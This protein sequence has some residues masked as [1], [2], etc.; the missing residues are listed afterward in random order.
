MV[1]LNAA[2]Q[3][4]N[5]A[6]DPANSVWLSANA[7]SGK[8]RVLT[9]RVARL[10]LD[11][12]DPQHILCLTY[13]RAAAGEM[14]NR[15]FKRLGRWA[16]M[17]ADDLRGSL[18]SLGVERPLSQDDL[19]AARTLFA[20]AIETP[21]GIKIQT[22]HSFCAAL[23]RR[24]PLEAGISPNVVEIDERTSLALRD[25]VV[26]DMLRGP[27]S[28]TVRSMARQLTDAD[29]SK[30]TA[31]V[32]RA[33]RVFQAPFPE[34]EVRARLGLTSEAPL[35][36]PL[37][38]ICRLA[39]PGLIET[40]ASVLAE[41][42]TNDQKA[43]P[44]LKPLIGRPIDATALPVLEA[45]LLKKTKPEELAQFPTKA[46]RE[47]LG[48]YEA[49]LDA[50]AEEVLALRPTRIA[51]KLFDQT[52][53]FWNFAS[54]FLRNYQQAKAE[55]GWL[56]YDD[57]IER[58]Q[59]L[60]NSPTVADWVLYRLDGGLDHILVDEAQDTSPAQWEII[61][62]IAREFS[63]G[64]GGRED[65]RRT[66]FVVGDKKQSI[67]SFQGADPEAFDRFRADFDDR[68]GAIGQPLQMHSLS[69]SFR[70]APAILDV[71]DAVIGKVPQGGLDRE[72][73]HRAFHQDLP[74][75][76]D[77]W[78]FRTGDEKPDAADW[79]A[80][81]DQ[82][83]PVDPKR[84]LADALAAE[85]SRLI[86]QETIQLQQD[87]EPV[88]RR[89]Q[90]GDFL[91]LFPTRSPLFHE[92]I[93]A[94]KRE[95][96]AVA[97]ADRLRISEELAV[98]DLKALLQ[99]L[100]L[101]EDDLSLAC[102]L[103]SPLFG[104][105]E[106]DL[107]DLAHKRLK[108]GKLWPALRT[109]REDVP[110]TM[111]IIDDLARQAEFLRPYDLLERI[112][113]R[114]D[115]RRRLLGRLGPDAEDA[116]DALLS[117]ALEF[118]SQGAADLT[119]FLVWLEGDA[120]EIKRAVDS[121]SNRIRI[122]TVHGAKGLEA[123]IV[124]LPDTNRTAPSLRDLT[125]TDTETALWRPNSAEEPAAARAMR[126]EKLAAEARERE[127]LLYVAMTRAECWLIVAGAGAKD[128]DPNGW[129]GVIAA[130]LQD[131]AQ[132]PLTTPMGEGLRV[133][134]TPWPDQAEAKAEVGEAKELP[135]AD[136]KIGPL[137]AVEP[138]K[139]FLS[140][141][142]LGGAKALPGESADDDDQGLLYGRLLHLLLE[143]LPTADAS[144]RPDLG[145][146]LLMQADEPPSADMG[147]RLLADAMRLLSDANLA[148]IFAPLTLREVGVT[149]APGGKALFGS[150]D[151]L[152]VGDSRLRIVDFKSNRVVPQS[153]NDVPEGILR[154]LGA[155][156]AMLE[157]IYPEHEIVPEI[158]WTA[159]GER[160]S[161]PHDIVR[162]A[163]ARA[164][165]P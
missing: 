130:A 57:L 56:D 47:A 155:Y 5:D 8:T 76:V 134:P 41:G 73:A 52:R 92:L 15:L 85:I 39:P 16:M 50:L 36:K 107:F 128:P 143:H 148:D 116:I 58:A 25:D 38:A 99:F 110:E 66:L 77:L 115:G 120:T 27:D 106:R 125:L 4:Q 88:I 59:A 18:R 35:E 48:P 142:D 12:V 29:F 165:T 22:I 144:E 13:T 70:S 21:G 124:I 54:A 71:V 65:V 87:G 1:K 151:A 159:T 43:L 7:G 100:A 91:I 122:M 3:A 153:E 53:V 32:M 131:R 89:I 78:P 64:Q 113:I 86:H 84:Q 68:L 111:S 152:I 154:Q 103:R 157:E 126:Q 114:H 62:S 40:L 49:T 33:A 24:F 28:D 79:F 140:P 138:A 145:R 161:I 45:L 20:R 90:P 127:R 44:T 105:S 160:M 63:S 14:Q 139:K 19:G 156:A 118:E 17:E 108:G 46:S 121:A 42:S 34:A 26:N 136:V 83:S 2:T 129:Y 101:P 51:Q 61:S 94:C 164:T 75:R 30:L 23:L 93:R 132:M 97:G 163:F 135:A 37:E 137:P 158:L 6:A 11:G 141:S 67:Y 123:P 133:E 102:A 81:L 55:R 82:M 117:Q 60:L 119:G 162:D 74:G 10:L 96:L 9:D 69:H 149:G 72:V 31:E 147:Q 95:G 104:W 146:A 98:R 80:P 112:L 150:I 109:M